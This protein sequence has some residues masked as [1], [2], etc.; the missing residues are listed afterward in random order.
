MVEGEGNGDDSLVDVVVWL[1]CLKSN[2]VYP[3]VQLEIN[4][5]EY[6]KKIKQGIII[7]TMME[8][9]SSSGIYEI[10]ILLIILFPRSYDEKEIIIIIVKKK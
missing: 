5:M 10:E 7:S 9:S 8:N 2:D 4:K 3:F 1:N 6:K